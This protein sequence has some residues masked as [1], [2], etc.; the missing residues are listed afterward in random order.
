MDYT[1]Q[2]HGARGDMTFGIGARYK[3]TAYNGD[4]NGSKSD[5]A[6][7]I[8]AAYSYALRKDTVLS[9]NVTNLLDE[10][11]REAAS[12]AITYNPG[13][14]ITATLRRTW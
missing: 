2:G 5:A 13:R 6:V 7:L 11:H 4:D 14:E 1:L 8:D 9:V 3:G 12:G 10:K